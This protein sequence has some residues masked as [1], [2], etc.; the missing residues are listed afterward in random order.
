M[1]IPSLFANIS[2]GSAIVV[3]A[4]LAT[5]GVFFGKLWKL[6]KKFSDLFDDLLGEPAR[7]GVPER[8]GIMKRMANLENELHNP[9]LRLAINE[10][11]NLLDNS[12]K[13]IRGELHAA[14]SERMLDNERLHT[15]NKILKKYVHEQNAVIGAIILELNRSVSPHHELALPDPIP[16]PVEYRDLD[17]LE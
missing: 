12:V 3:I 7:S 14:V 5:V 4:T 11:R 13:D 8:P 2:I 10:L 15:E 6:L 17:Q 16:L 1:D 9:S